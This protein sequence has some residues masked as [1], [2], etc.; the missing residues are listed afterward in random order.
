[1][2]NTET[3]DNWNAKSS[4]APGNNISINKAAEA[5]WLKR[6]LSL[7]INLDIIARSTKIRARITEYPSPAIKENIIASGIAGI[8]AVDLLSNIIDLD[9]NLDTSIRLIGSE[10]SSVQ[11]TIIPKFAPDTTRIC[12]VAVL[13]KASYP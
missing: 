11:K 2:D 13:V 6:S 1:M 5:R 3:N 4:I 7:L 9:W 12:A 8:Y 10:A